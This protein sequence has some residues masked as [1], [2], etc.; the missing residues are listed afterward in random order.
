[1]DALFALGITF[2]CF[3]AAVSCVLHTYYMRNVVAPL[4]FSS[5]NVLS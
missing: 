4:L 2:S 3:C 5:G 1:M